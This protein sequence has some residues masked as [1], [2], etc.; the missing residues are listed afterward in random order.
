MRVAMI[1]VLMMFGLTVSSI[2][3]ETAALGKT[4]SGA[5]GAEGELYIFRLGGD[6]SVTVDV[7]ASK[8]VNVTI[9]DANMQPVLALDNSVPE[10]N[11][12]QLVADCAAGANYVQV[13]GSNAE[14]DLTVSA[15]VVAKAAA[16]TPK[17]AVN[18]V[19]D[20]TNITIE[21][22]QGTDG[23]LQQFEFYNDGLQ[24]IEYKIRSDAS[25]V[26]NPDPSAGAIDE[27]YRPEK[28]IV[29]FS[30]RWMPAG[31]Y[32]ANLFIEGWGISSG[33]ESEYTG[34]LIAGTPDLSDETVVIQIEGEFD[35]PSGD[36]IA[37][38]GELRITAS[39]RSETMPYSGRSVAGAGPFTVLF[40]TNHELKNTF[41]N[42]DTLVV[43]PSEDAN[44]N[45]DDTL[46]IPI[47]LTV[48]ARSAGGGSGG[49]GVSNAG[50]WSLAPIALL[51]LA[52][53]ATRFMRRHET[54]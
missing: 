37:E 20:I 27:P 35:I 54:A 16:I 47:T 9:L 28:V 4:I 51:I 41:T 30:N 53:G 7:E 26:E 52:V 38:S 18:I 48:V 14:F 21:T 13:A 2:G 12:Y 40:T 15:N 3:A 50:L 17:A 11:A 31:T 45:P 19:A 42:G 49:C 10:S 44:D 22:S 1:A 25:W 29:T 24:L 43:I 6:A 39:G 32:T 5:T 36:L 34:T 33:E 8:E 46:T 23:P